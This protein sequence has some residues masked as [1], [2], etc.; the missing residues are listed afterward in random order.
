MKYILDKNNHHDFKS[1]EYGRLAPRAYGI[2][3]TKKKS[4]E[5]SDAASCKEVDDANDEKKDT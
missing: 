1:V 5:K 2:P 3:H 4:A